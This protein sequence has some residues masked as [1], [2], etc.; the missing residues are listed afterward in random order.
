MI[1]SSVTI[2]KVTAI[3]KE[4]NIKIL[5][6]N[7]FAT[8]NQIKEYV[9]ELRKIMK[10]HNIKTKRS[11]K[12]HINEIYAHSF[13]YKHHLFIENTKDTDL[14]ENESLFRRFIYSMIYIFF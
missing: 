7:T 10:K 14:E 4:N 3:F 11:I 12:S 1:L 5:S 6:T 13:L 2:N 8:K 9:I